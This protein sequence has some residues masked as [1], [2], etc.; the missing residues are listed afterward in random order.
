[1]WLECAVN[2]KVSP[3]V[4]IPQHLVFCV[5]FCFSRPIWF[6]LGR[7]VVSNCLPNTPAFYNKDL[8]VVKF[9]HNVYHW[10]SLMF[11]NVTP[12]RWWRHPPFS[13]GD[14]FFFTVSFRCHSPL[15]QFFSS[16]SEDAC[17]TES[18]PLLRNSSTENGWVFFSPSYK[19]K[20]LKLRNL[21]ALP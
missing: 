8:T 19:I 17:F 14:S 7:R 6:M 13:V 2:S 20:K 15:P 10:R 18:T 12:S 11:L 21:W 3:K 16:R 9:S 4:S 5:S 1:M